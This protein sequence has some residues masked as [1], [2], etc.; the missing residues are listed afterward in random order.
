[1]QALVSGMGGMGLDYNAPSTQGGFA[2]R[3]MRRVSKIFDCKHSGGV[4][5]YIVFFII[6]YLVW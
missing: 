2:S 1:M 6:I 3:D 5:C 4:F